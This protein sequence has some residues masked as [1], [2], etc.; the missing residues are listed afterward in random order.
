MSDLPPDEVRRATFR[1]AF[2]GFAPAE[3]RETLGHLADRIAD[4]EAE[5]EE[6]R[7]RLGDDPARLLSHAQAD[8]ERLRREAWE[9]GTKVLNDAVSGAREIMA[10]TDREALARLGQAERDAHRL[11]GESRRQA[12]KLLRSAR[13]QAGLPVQELPSDVH[14]DDAAGIVGVHH[15]GDPN[16]VGPDSQAGERGGPSTSVSDEPQVQRRRGRRAG[17]RRGADFTVGDDPETRSEDDTEW[18]VSR[19]IRVIRGDAARPISTG[20]ADVDRTEDDDAIG[21]GVETETKDALIDASMDDIAALFA[22]L[23]TSE[24]QTATSLPTDLDGAGVRDGLLLPIANR[25]LRNVKRQ[26]TEAQNVALE[27]LRVS[28]DWAADAADLNERIQPDLI[29]LGQEAFAAGYSAAE[30]FTG[31]SAGR[32]KPQSGDLVDSGPG[33]AG[34]LAKALEEALAEGADGP[35]A[36]AALA[37]RVFRAW[38]TDEAERRVRHEALIG[39]H[40]GLSRALSSLGVGS[41]SWQVAGSG[42]DKCQSAEAAGPVEVGKP[43]PG[44]SG[45]APVHPGCDCTIVPVN[46]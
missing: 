18:S 6:L 26:L 3:V 43:F 5:R 39:Y 29:V 14:D 40:R 27:Q 1:Q 12:E 23:R 24:G 30:Q 28:K 16:I 19:T 36:R 38:R 7:L 20:E 22:S 46:G 37:S 33:F 10:A 8:S 32:A 25:V 15:G 35:K 31:R 2:R 17:R 42:C 45:L 9:V 41:Y 13:M 44:A 11:T 21:Q 34:S 4:L